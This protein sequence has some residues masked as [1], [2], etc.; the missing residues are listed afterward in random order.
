MLSRMPGSVDTVSSK[1]RLDMWTVIY[2][3]KLGIHLVSLR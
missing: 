2:I 3:P 1:A